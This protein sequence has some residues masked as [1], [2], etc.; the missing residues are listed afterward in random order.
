M[1]NPILAASETKTN[2]IV[3]FGRRQRGF[4][5]I[6]VLVALV[7]LSL[8]LLGLAALQNMGLKLGN[9]SYQRTQATLLVYEM[10]DRMRANAAGVD[11]GAYQLQYT[12]PVPIL[13]RDC[14]LGGVACTATEMAT[15]DMNQWLST[16]TGTNNG[17]NVVQ[18]PA[19]PVLAAASGAI[20]AQG[21]SLYD[22][23]IR[24]QEQD[25]TQEQTVRVQLP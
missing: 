25:V 10:I 24:W 11:A 1:C 19:R 2:G 22:V 3:R 18:N 20:L 6:E 5:L 23:S 15:Y 8:G 9:E 17:T 21:N 13:T 7:V 14:A 16:L 12:D 4:N